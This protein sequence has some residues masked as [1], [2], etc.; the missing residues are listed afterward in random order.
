MRDVLHLTKKEVKKMDLLEYTDALNYCWI[1]YKTRSMVS[2]GIDN[3]S[4][5]KGKEQ[6]HL[7]FD[8]SHIK[9]RIEEGFVSSIGKSENSWYRGD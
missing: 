1:T 8:Q 5:S 9:K 3:N 6:L 4:K 7:E 2:G